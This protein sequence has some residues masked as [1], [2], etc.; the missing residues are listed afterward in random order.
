MKYPKLVMGIAAVLLS[1]T[2]LGQTVR[3]ASKNFTEQFVL[4]EL[5]AQA[6]EAAG[7]KVERTMLVAALVSGGI[8]GL[9][10]VSEV[11]GIHYHL[12]DAISGGSGYTGIIVATLGGLNPLGAGV[13]ALFIGL[14]DTGSQSVSRALGVPVYLGDVILATLL[15][16]TL[17]TLLL[18]AYRIR[19]QTKDSVTRNS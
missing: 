19:W 2:A 18:R 17:A 13:A 10:G 3:V 6:F 16:V 1:A 7:I 4:A 5:Y 15:L 9:A 11:A 14:I 8:A 12:I